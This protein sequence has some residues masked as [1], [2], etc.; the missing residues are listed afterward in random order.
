MFYL[1]F[2]LAQFRPRQ[3]PVTAYQKFFESYQMF[4]LP[5]FSKSYDK[6]QQQSSSTSW[7]TS[8]MACK[9]WDAQSRRSL[10]P[11]P[12]V[13]ASGCYDGQGS[14]LTNTSVQ[15]ILQELVIAL[16]L[17]RLMTVCDGRAF[18]IVCDFYVLQSVNTR[19]S[20]FSGLWSDCGHASRI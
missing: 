7:Q 19:C 4:Q 2:R 11:L 3:R 14:T 8:L 15:Q 12:A 5:R 18:D 9:G 6:V 1:R 16:K 17:T 20:I 10:P 13:Q